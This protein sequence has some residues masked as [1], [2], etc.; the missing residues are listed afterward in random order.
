MQVPAA[1]NRRIR[2]DQHDPAGQPALGA[3]ILVAVPGSSAGYG[4]AARGG[5]RHS[6]RVTVAL[7]AASSVRA[8]TPL[9]EDQ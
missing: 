9:C 5:F 6:W 1:F 3:A 8:L 4:S 2:R 7:P